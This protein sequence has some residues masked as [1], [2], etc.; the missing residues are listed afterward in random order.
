[1]G[2]LS[3]HFN[4]SEFFCRHCGAGHGLIS[5]DLIK[6]LEAIRE[7]VGVPLVISSGYRCPEHNTAVNGGPEH[8]AGQAADI[9]ASDNLKY[10]LVD[11]AYE[12]GIMRIGVGASFVHVGVGTTLPQFVLWGY[13]E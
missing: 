12:T 3:P 13:A 1:M 6:A 7:V 8:P 4:E 5:P 2:D 9:V 10:R 11:A